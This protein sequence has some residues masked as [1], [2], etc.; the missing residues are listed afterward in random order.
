MYMHAHDPCKVEA[1]NNEENGIHYPFVVLILCDSHEKYK[2]VDTSITPYTLAK[3]ITH[4]C[5]CKYI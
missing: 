1:L 5:I 2:G 3:F 4:Y